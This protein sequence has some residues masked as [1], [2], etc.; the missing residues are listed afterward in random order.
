MRTI[1]SSGRAITKPRGAALIA[2]ALFG[3]A[4]DGAAPADYLPGK[5]AWRRRLA[6]WCRNP[7]HN[8]TFYVIGC[9]DRD[10]LSLGREPDKVFLDAAGW[11]WAWTFAGWLPRPF[12]SYRGTTWRGYIGWRPPGGAFGLKWQRNRD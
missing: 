7:L 9:V 2:W 8:L 4:D 1:E 11:N 5:P 3:N 12:V 10:S 6:W